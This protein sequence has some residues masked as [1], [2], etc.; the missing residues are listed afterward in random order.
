MKYLLKLLASILGATLL[1]NAQLAHAAIT[2]S[3]SATGVTAIYNSASGIATTGSVTVNCARLNSDSAANVT[4]YI[5]L[6]QGEPPG[7]RN[8]TRQNGAQLLAY[9]IFRNSD[10]TGSWTAGAGRN[11]GASQTGGLNVPIIWA[12]A[13]NFTTTISYYFQVV[14]GINRPAGIYD[15]ASITFRIFTARNVTPQLGEATFTANVSIPAECFFTTPPSTLDVN[16][17][18]FVGTNQTGSTGYSVSCTLN[19]VYSMAVS[20]ATGTLLGLNYSLALNSA[21]GTGTAF[22]QNYTVTATVPS[23]QSGICN[24][25]TCTATQPS[26]ITITY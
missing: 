6:D 7:G 3:L 26:T 23:G 14:A 19:T 25:G 16:Y 5:S 18:S 17:T 11:P 10:N 13:T 8:M 24:T 12:G 21:S 4:Y 15:D 1:L 22:P 20:P 9:R 2:C